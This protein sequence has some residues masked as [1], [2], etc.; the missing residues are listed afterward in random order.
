MTTEAPA[1]SERFKVAPWWRQW[2]RW[3]ALPATLV[4]A[5]AAITG[6]IV[7]GTEFFG[8]EEA[9]REATRDLVSPLSLGAPFALWSDRL[10]SALSAVAAQAP[11]APVDRITMQFKGDKPTITIFTGKP[12]GG[13]DRRFVVD[14]NSG[15]INE[16]ASYADKPLVHR[17]HSGEAFGDGGLVVAMFWGASLAF[18]SVSG[19][20]LYVSLW[21]RSRAGLKRYFW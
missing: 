15:R 7:A 14:A 17:I 16:V 21:R 12:T 6:V 19:L 3:I 13:E 20:M 5:F 10:N 9:L 11:N 8:A 1:S 2:H 4:L 18:L